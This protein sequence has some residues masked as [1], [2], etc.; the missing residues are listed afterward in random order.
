M[1]NSLSLALLE[2]NNLAPSFVVTDA[3]SK[4]SHSGN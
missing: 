2:V 3:C 4:S 1:G